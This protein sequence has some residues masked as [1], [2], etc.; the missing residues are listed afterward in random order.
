MKVYSKRLFEDKYIGYH[1][2]GLTVKN[3]TY[4]TRNTNSVEPPVVIKNDNT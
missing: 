3:C 1:T 4:E 2:F